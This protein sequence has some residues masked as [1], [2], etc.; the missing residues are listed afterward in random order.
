MISD[1][2]IT[3]LA[4]KKQTVQLN[5]RR[6]YFQ[7]LFLS[8]FYQESQAG[9]IF[10]KGGTAFRLIY[11]SPRFSEDLDFSTP[12]SNI[13]Q[14]EDIVQNTL[15]EIERE[16]ITLEIIE[17]KETTGGYL[18]IIE[19]KLAREKVTIRT[20]VSFR[21]KKVKGEVI[22]IVNDFIPPYTIVSLVREQ[23]VNQK[24]QALLSRQKPRDFY[25]L[26]FIL[27]A[28]LLPPHEKSIL[29]KVLKSLKSLNISF[30]KE[31][32]NFLP[33]SHWAMIKDFKSALIGEIQKFV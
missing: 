5:I 21:D 29:P 4:V 22:T 14:I 20:E 12:L 3:D 13:K 1:E 9:S 19:F 8:Y 10:F 6:E 17:S 24:I 30:E 23:L 18:S 7:H 11:N 26:Y 2:I 27:R 25:D 31:L 15:K 33:K 28:N 32:E 16:G